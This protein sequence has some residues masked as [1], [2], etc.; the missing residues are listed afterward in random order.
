[1][2]ACID[3]KRKTTFF[4]WIIQ[5]FAVSNRVYFL[6]NNVGIHFVLTYYFPLYLFRLVP[7]FSS[8][9]PQIFFDGRHLQTVRCF[10]YA[11]KCVLIFGV[12][13]PI[14]YPFNET[15]V[16]LRLHPRCCSSCFP[17]RRTN[18]SISCNIQPKWHIFCSCSV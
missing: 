11:T 16:S 1:M 17:L 8:I 14:R 6:S 7:M 18:V 5:Y 4:F 15:W 3:P 9:S 12:K 2:F 10:L 13:L